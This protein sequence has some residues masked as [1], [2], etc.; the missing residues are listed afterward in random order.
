VALSAEFLPIVWTYLTE[1]AICREAFAAAPKR[2]RERRG[3]LIAMI[4]SGLVEIGLCSA[5]MN[6]PLPSIRT[7]VLETLRAS[8]GDR[9]E[10][11]DQTNIVH[12]LGLDSVTIMDF[13]MEIEDRLDIS[14]PLDR[15]AEVETIGDL[16]ATL[17]D[18]K[19][20]G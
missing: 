12:E 18:L 17:R 15:I 14:V 9:V 2:E 3:T 20:K 5:A 10:L 7:V 1:S 6:D 11:S 8:T 16:V 19:G 4:W 13:V